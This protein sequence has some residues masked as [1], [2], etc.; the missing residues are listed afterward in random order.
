LSND[1]EN[2]HII[3]SEGAPHFGNSLEKHNEVEKGRLWLGT[4]NPKSK[5]IQKEAVK[6][7]SS[8]SRH[9]LECISRTYLTS[10]LVLFWLEYGV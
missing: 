5:Y 4:A 9:H 7:G 8:F 10:R 2:F 1:K 3:N 6:E